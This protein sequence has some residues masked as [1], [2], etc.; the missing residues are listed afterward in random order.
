VQIRRARPWILG[1]IAVAVG[2][3]GLNMAARHLERRLVVKAQALAESA[4]LRFTF[5]DVHVGI[6]PPF[7]MRGIL[8]EG[9]GPA[10][11]R[12]GDLTASPWPGKGFGLGVRVWVDGV[13]ASLPAEIE[14]RL[15]PSTWDVDPSGS[16]DLRS[17]SGALSVTAAQGGKGRALDLKIENLP[18]DQFMAFELEGVKNGDLGP[19]NAEV[20]L[21]GDPETDFQA[22]WRIEAVG[23]HTS[24]TMVV[25]PDGPTPVLEV[26]S[27]FG[28]VDFRRIFGALGLDGDDTGP[29]G[30]LRGE[31]TAAG[32]VEDLASLKVDQDIVFT[33]PEQIPAA[34]TRLKG[35]FTHPVITNLGLKKRID[36]SPESPAFIALADVPPLFLRALLIA[37][38]AAF[39][40]HPG[41]DLAEMP[42]A[43]ATNW[44][45]GEAVRGAST[46]TQQLAKNLFLSREKSLHRKLKELSYSFLLEDTL[47]K[48]R[49]LEIYLNI[50]E[51]G[52]GLYGLK[53]A[54]RHYFGK[55]PQAL[56]PKEI[57]FLVSMIPGPIK[58]QR[59]I[60]GDELGLG[61]ENLVNNLLVKLRSVE[62]LSE[63]EYAAA[64]E[65]TLQFQ[66]TELEPDPEPGEEVPEAEPPQAQAPD[67]ATD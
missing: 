46:I 53:P 21:E 58:Y 51:W 17:P 57:A 7:R 14:V 49:I 29:L 5:K 43:I 66:W 33:P 10:S 35:P 41:I 19:L 20:H 56:T 32:P 52:P 9:P 55:E 30:S 44:A 61:F 15:N 3:V 37:E 54:A 25:A 12:I 18:L 64:R 42:R 47:G 4:G 27:S 31:I 40:S 26:T 65:E 60:Q 62:A 36:V 13:S 38:D 45:R 63:E 11:V 50:I 22:R 1:G 23:G 39:F 24:G 48:S 2:A 59:S 67:P 8:I 34:L 6:I 16:L 28:D